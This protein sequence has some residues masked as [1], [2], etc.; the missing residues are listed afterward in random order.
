MIF[1]KVRWNVPG[2]PE[3]KTQAHGGI[4]DFSRISTTGNG[5]VKKV[6]ACAP[7]AV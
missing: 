2:W 4:R 3:R 5:V 6:C 1:G 7:E